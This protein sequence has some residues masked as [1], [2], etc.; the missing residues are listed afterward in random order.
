MRVADGTSLEDSGVPGGDTRRAALDV[1]AYYE[2]A[3]TALADHVPE[4]RQA[5][6]WFFR[7]TETGDVL[8]RAQAALEAADAPRAAWD[9]IVPRGQQGK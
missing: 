8:K 1:R 5:E 9:F 4:A 2:E 7:R 3:A 6:S